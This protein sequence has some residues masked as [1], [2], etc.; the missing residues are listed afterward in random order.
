MNLISYSTNTYVNTAIYAYRAISQKYDFMKFG[1]CIIVHG[2]GDLAVTKI[3]NN[4]N[5]QKRGAIPL[6]FLLYIAF[7]SK[8]I[9]QY[10]WQYDTDIT[11][12]RP[13]HL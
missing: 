12:C 11:L 5:L 8:I 6:Y 2:L 10:N 7:L 3:D 1:G 13:R 9:S 4:Y